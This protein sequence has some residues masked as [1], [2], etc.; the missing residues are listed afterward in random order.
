MK[1][2]VTIFE[3]LYPLSGGG[4]PRISNIIQAFARG[5]HEVC[6]VGGIAS[7]A[8]EAKNYLGCREIVRLKTVSRLDPNKMKK[9]LLAHPINMASLLRA[10]RTFKP[11]LIVSHNTVAGYGSLMGRSLS[12]VNPLL[13]LNLTDLLFEYL[14]TYSSGGW[15]STV[16]K[17]GRKM[18]G[19]AIRGSD[20]IITISRAMKEIILGYGASGEKID[21]VCDGVDLNIF[22]KY[23][24]GDLRREH[25]PGKETVLIFQ[26]V[27]DPQ[28]G[29]ELLV[30]AAGKLR[31]EKPGS[32]FWIIGAGTAIPALKERVRE[33]GLTDAFY[34]SG[35]LTQKEVARYMSAGDIG[36]V[37]LP[38]IVSAR[39]RVTLKEFE[40]WACGL[41]VVAPR[42]P[43]LEEVIEE[44]KTGLF[45][46]PGNADDLVEKISALI[47]DPDLSG[48]MGEEGLRVVEEKYRWDKLADE[49]V[50]LC[51]GYR[52]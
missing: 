38:D 35:W 3:E 13:V 49:F 5:G 32:A 50:R 14:D 18:E 45:Y 48:K 26:G 9:Y 52:E 42:L 8:E 6:V 39:G 36:L 4:S 10:I 29:P 30:A 17:F 1:V 21:I 25:A 33:E 34:F 40:Y 24:S 28:D 43:A 11:D 7:S 51:E 46:Q 37:I 2:L 15:L 22:R 31:A 16:Q 23:E 20:R 27:I 12:R 44:G 47:D 19:A 41:S